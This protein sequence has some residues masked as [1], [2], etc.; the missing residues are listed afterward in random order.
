MIVL[1]LKLLCLVLL[2]YALLGKGFAYLGFPPLYVSEMLLGMGVLIAFLNPK[3]A[4]HVASPKRSFL[5]VYFMFVWGAIRT[6]AYIPEYGLDALRDAA[7]WGY[8]LF[9]LLIYAAVRSYPWLLEWLL[10]R[11]RGFASLFPPIIIM[12]LLAVRLPAV[13][14]LRVPGTDNIRLLWAKPGD[15]AVHLA[16]VVGLYLVGLGKKGTKGIWLFSVV[17]ALLLV[18]TNRG[19]ILSFLCS[20]GAV[21]LVKAGMTKG[22]ATRLFRI[23]FVAWVIVS[24]FLAVLVLAPE[25]LARMVPLDRMR[26]K[27]KSVL[28]AKDYTGTVIDRLAWWSTIV[29]YTLL[30]EHFWTGK[31][32]GINLAEDDG[33]TWSADPL[34]APLRSPHNAHMNMLARA[35]V[36]GFL[37]WLLVQGGWVFALARAYRSARR[38]KIIR[39]QQIFLFLIGYWTA[40]MI[41]ASFDVF[42]EGPMGGIWFWVVY[43]FG[44][45]AVGQ[46]RREL[47]RLRSAAQSAEPEA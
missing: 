38:H 47:T 37:L 12:L 27:Y 3:V 29:D 24:L 10:A 13:A 22:M 43:G 25:T 33:F 42:L 44:V 31:G 23:G 36:P 18:T 7:L 5:P 35:G 26:A 40:F 28:Y 46:Y 1:Y 21:L 6:I 20:L 2:G 45:A 16:G 15:T 30:G 32:F 4:R 17:I 11:Y 19:G 9:A 8:A 14:R 39:W 41:N 34:A